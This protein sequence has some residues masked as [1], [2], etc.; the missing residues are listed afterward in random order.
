VGGTCW[1]LEPHR[2]FLG[3]GSNVD[4]LGYGG[5]VFLEHDNGGVRRTPWRWILV[6]SEVGYMSCVGANTTGRVRYEVLWTAL[7]VN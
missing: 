6:C 5:D 1:I 7:E 4:E 3:K 2:I